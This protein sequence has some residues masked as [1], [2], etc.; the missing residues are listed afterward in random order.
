MTS[1]GRVL[2]KGRR[3][4]N[5]GDS[6][7]EQLT[8]DGAFLRAER[9]LDTELVD[10][11]ILQLNR[12]YPQMLSDKEAT[13]FRKLDVPTRVRLGE[14]LTHLQAKGEEACREFY[15]AL[16]LHVEDVYYSLPTRLRLRGPLFFI[17]C[18]SV[19]VG[20]ALV[21]YLGE[22]KVTGGSG[23]LGMAALGL[24]RKASEVLVWYTEES[25]KK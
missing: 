7:H 19:A 17:S 6:F 5:M 10:K 23:A 12:I 22:A 4:S 25:F 21:Y 24:K 9:R 1:R 11:I 3:D 8:E 15:R 2:R 14:L 18:F 16:H 13:K 20:L